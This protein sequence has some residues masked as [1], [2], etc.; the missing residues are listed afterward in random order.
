VVADCQAAGA[1]V[2]VK[3]LGSNSIDYDRRLKLKHRKGGDPEEWPA[4]LRVRELPTVLTK[5]NP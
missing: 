2:F 3:Q 1:P 5:E 4:D